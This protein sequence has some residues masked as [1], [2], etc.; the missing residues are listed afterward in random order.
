MTTIVLT[1]IVLAILLAIV[2]FQTFVRM[3]GGGST[4][5][6]E[7][8]RRLEHADPLALLH[9]AVDDG[10][11]S[12]QDAKK[13]LENYRSLILAVQRQVENGEKEK[14][15]LEGRIQEAI[16]AGDP[17]HTAQEFAMML[18]D[19]EQNI[20]ANCEQ[21]QRHK[22]TYENFAKQVEAGQNRVQAAREKAELLGLELEQSER[23]KGNGPL[24]TKLLFQ[25]A[26]VRHGSVARRGTRL[27]EDRRQPSRRSDHGL[28]DRAAG[29]RRIDGWR[30][31]PQ[32]CRREDTRTFHEAAADAW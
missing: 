21:L 31:G 4:E 8:A 23:E 24:R 12:I 9:Q 16:A 28:P 1:L 2:N 19:V 32:S 15:R 18:A 11:A 14:A 17:K 7:A 6:I 10:V 5:P 22:E 13:G 30:E 25:S 29:L 26:R 3:L 27:P 20:A